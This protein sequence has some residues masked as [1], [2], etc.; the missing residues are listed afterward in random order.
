MA[1]KEKLVAADVQ[2]N[3]EGGQAPPSVKEVEKKLDPNAPPAESKV[4]LIRK[5]LA[6][7]VFVQHLLI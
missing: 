3:P 4:V 1:D 2:A 5:L 6:E 7:H